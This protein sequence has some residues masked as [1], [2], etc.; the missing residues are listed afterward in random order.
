MVCGSETWVIRKAEEDVLWRAERAMVCMI[1]GEK[2]RDRKSSSELMSMA[3]SCEDI[4][5]VVRRSR[6]CGME[7]C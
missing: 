5:V 4:V 1:S 7:M 3:G 6:L 2:L